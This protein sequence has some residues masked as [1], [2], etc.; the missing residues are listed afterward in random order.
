MRPA[1]VLALLLLLPHPGS[2]A[3][4]KPRNPDL[5]RIRFLVKNGAADLALRVLSGLQPNPSHPTE[6]MEWERVRFAIHR[7]K[8]DWDALAE[9]L[10][11]LP[12]TLPSHLR[13]TLV[14][15]GVEVLLDAGR[16]HTV[17]PHLRQLLWTGSFDSRQM[18]LWR[19]L[20][21]R[22]Y[23]SEGLLEDAH[24][25]MRRYQREFLP[26]DAGW[27]ILYARVLLQSGQPAEASS[28]LATSQS[29]EG[30]FLRL[31]GR[32]RAKTDMPETVMAQARTLLDSLSDDSTLHAAFWALVAEA[33]RYA[34]EAT[35]HADALERVYQHPAHEFSK[36]LFERDV[37][38]LWQAY[39]R[40]GESVGNAENLLIGDDEAW[41]E[42]ADALKPSE[43]V[44]A[45]SIYALLAQRAT[46]QTAAERH[47]LR[48]YRSLEES[49][50]VE[51]AMRLYVEND[52]YKDVETIPKAIRYELVNL[53]LAR[54]D[55]SLAASMAIALDDV[56][57]NIDPWD[58][59]LKRARLALYSGRFE[60]GI[61][62]LDELVESREVLDKG[63]VDRILQPVFDL[64]AIEYYSASYG[65][66]EKM[67]VRAEEAEQQR[68]I[69]FWMGDALRG[70]GKFENAVE[71][72]L[73][74][75]LFAGGGE[76]MWGQTARYRA[77]EALA[78]AGLTDDARRVYDS[79]LKSTS[80]PNRKAILE[81]SL[82]QLS[83]KERQRPDGGDGK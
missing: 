51:T 25:A 28:Y 41:L 3:A 78:E 50:L 81:R 65:L 32:L 24:I 60:D 19:R 35:A 44:R 5:T 39:V 8:S 20:T 54:R 22:S 33:S 49:G 45:R 27:S 16:G 67:Y 66:L 29:S 47:H 9:R 80:D 31:L 26:N 63:A 74:A 82:Q 75:A 52:R 69:L 43:P 10:E 79:L 18:D 71:H 21:I 14:T 40:L 42:I 4:D 59:G 11:S 83:L 38:Q 57:A 23:L 72:Y 1:Y 56:E 36:G 6:W 48:L 13:H 68:E 34:D 77:A 62:I 15:Q 37:N 61:R 46:N 53:A 73:R 70:E 17:R 2:W 12:P 58:W 64:Q 55:I 30:R 76:D 7:S